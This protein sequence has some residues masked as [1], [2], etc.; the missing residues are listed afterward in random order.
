MEVEA[1]TEVDAAVVEVGGGRL[2]SETVRLSK[3]FED[4]VFGSESPLVVLADAT[5][6][7]EA[8]RVGAGVGVG[9][10]EGD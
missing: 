6:A 7:G 1:E 10:G 5:G 9:V 4:T 3:V 8:E 2:E